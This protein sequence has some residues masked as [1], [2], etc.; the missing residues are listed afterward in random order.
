MSLISLDL[1]LPRT[2]SFSLT[3]LAFSAPQ[4]STHITLPWI[5]EATFGHTLGIRSA[6][7][8]SLNSSSVLSNLP[9]PPDLVHWGRHYGERS[10]RFLHNEFAPPK[11]TDSKKEQDG[12]V[13]FYHFCNGIDYSAGP[14]ALEEYVLAAVGLEKRDDG[15]FWSSNANPAN[16]GVY[17]SKQMVV[18]VCTYNLFSKLELR[19]RVLVLVPKLR[20]LAV[21]VD[22]LYT[23]TVNLLKKLHSYN[24]TSVQE[25]SPGFWAELAVSTLVRMFWALDDPSHQVCGTVSVPSQLQNSHDVKLAVDRAVKLLPRGHLAG[26]RESFGVSTASGEGHKTSKYR[27]RLVDT[28][29]RVVLLD[30]SGQTAEYAVNEVQ[31]LFGTQYDVVVC[32]LLRAQQNANNDQR[33]L[34][35][36][37]SHLQKDQSLTQAAL[38]MVEQTRFL[39]GKGLFATAEKMAAKAVSLLPLD[40]DCWYHLALCYILERKFDTALR[41]INSLPVAMSRG[42]LPEDAV[43]GLYDAYAMTYMERMVSGLGISAELFEKFFPPPK[44]EREENERA[45]EKDKEADK[46]NRDL[47]RDAGSVYGIWYLEFRQRPHL[48][49]PMAGPFHQSPLSSATPIEIS[50]VDPQ[51]LKVSGPSSPKNL[52]AAQSGSTPWISI[53]DF[54]RTSTWGRTYDLL[55]VLVAIIGWDNLVHTKAK[56]FRRSENEKDYVVDH[57]TCSREECQPWLEQLFLVVYDDIRAMMV[58]SN[59]DADRSALLWEMIGLVGWS[60]KYNLKD[61]ISSI[62][63]SVAGVA[64]EGGFDY[65]GTVK[66]LEIYEEFVLS[67]VESSSIDRLSSVYDNRS[68]SNK[69]IVQNVSP[70]V[71]EEFSRQLTEGYLTLEL[72]LLHVMKYVSWNLRW[73][74]YVPSNLATSVLA[75]LCVKYDFIYI[76][77]MLRVVYETYK[78]QRKKKLAGLVLQLFSA[79]SAKEEHAPQFAETDTVVDYMDRL[80]TWIETLQDHTSGQNAQVAS[81]E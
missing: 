64:A 39:I 37:H 20:K 38:L 75:K 59:A 58:V 60:C 35:L 63:T 72:V 13:G 46:R 5:R 74:Q 2:Q 12:Y 21:L 51:I 29:K 30:I 66:L 14:Q 6:T 26:C 79:P 31:T 17:N 34:Q 55:T 32:L 40:F 52:L 56:M 27:N 50:A 16:Y 10:S 73:Y 18:T 53:L 70:K 77:S 42:K 67:E 61:S 48:R 69:L 19:A 81:P 43:D 24:Q 9:G 78:V 54:D 4:N 76:R 71:L 44:T 1:P 41:T 8:G 25:V 28:L 11:A 68:Y 65:F 15:V 7:L 62:V 80:L 45:K 3:S 57:S 23:I 49:H 47:L 33:L 22:A 36:I